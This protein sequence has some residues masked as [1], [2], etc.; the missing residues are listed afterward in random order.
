MMAWN[1][2]AVKYGGNHLQCIAFYYVLDY[3]S[4]RFTDGR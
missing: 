4:L 2:T 1:V 3:Y